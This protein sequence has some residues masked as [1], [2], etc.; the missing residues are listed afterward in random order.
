M[1]GGS[2]IGLN[3]G[4]VRPRIEEQSQDL[5]DTKVLSQNH[6]RASGM[7]DKKSTK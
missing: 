5:E 6:T 4:A 1:A 2:K 7:Y 3:L